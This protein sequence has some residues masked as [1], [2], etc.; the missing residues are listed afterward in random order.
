MPLIPANRGV[1][2]ELGPSGV[3]KAGMLLFFAYM[4]FDAVSAAAAETRNPSRNLPLG[5]LISLAVC[6][7]L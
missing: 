1:F 3:F 4:G 6:A 5:I 2:G 7:A